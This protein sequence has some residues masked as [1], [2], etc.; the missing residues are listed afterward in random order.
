MALMPAEVDARS[1][2]IGW[3]A[4]AAKITD[5]GVEVVGT[6]SGTLSRPSTV[7]DGEVR[8]IV[9]VLE[10][11]SEEDPTQDVQRTPELL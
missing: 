3:A 2:T 11:L 7:T 5:D 4:V 9:A 6:I 8:A 1:R 10:A